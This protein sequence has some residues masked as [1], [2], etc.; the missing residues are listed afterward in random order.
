MR[1]KI[2]IGESYSPTFMHGLTWIYGLTL[3]SGFIYYLY[4][5][6]HF[7]FH[8]TLYVS[9]FMFHVGCHV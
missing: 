3:W 2:H 1:W 9:D 5:L 4:M 7:I 8:L 6:S